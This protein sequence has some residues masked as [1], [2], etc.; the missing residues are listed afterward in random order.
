MPGPLPTVTEDNHPFVISSALDVS[1]GYAPEFITGKITWDLH[2]TSGGGRHPPDVTLSKMKELGAMTRDGAPLADRQEVLSSCWHQHYDATRIEFIS[3]FLIGDE[4][5]GS[6]KLNKTEAIKRLVEHNAPF[7]P[8]SILNAHLR[9]GLTKFKGKST[10]PTVTWEESYSKFCEEVPFGANVSTHNRNQQKLALAIDFWKEAMVSHNAD[11]PADKILTLSDEEVAKLSGSQF[12]L[13]VGGTPV[14]KKPA[15]PT[16]A[17]LR[18]K[19]LL[20]TT[21]V[22]DKKETIRQAEDLERKAAELRDSVSVSSHGSPS[23]RK[24]KPDA[25][26]ADLDN[27]G[28][29]ALLLFLSATKRKVELGDYID[30]ASMSAS[31]MKEIK[32]LNCAS[33]KSSRLSAGLVLRHSLSEADVTILTDDFSQISDGFLYHYLKVVSESNLDNPLATVI[34]R[35]SWWQW[36]GR[37][38]GKNFAAQV[39]FIKNFLLEHHSEPFWTPLVKLE[40]NLV[41]LCKEQAPLPG[42]TNAAKKDSSSKPAGKGKGKGGKGNNQSRVVVSAAQQKKIDSWKV[43]FPRT[44]VSRMV[45]GRECGREKSG[46]VCA[47]THNCAWCGSASCKADCS[48]AELL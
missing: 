5:R 14:F 3:Q 43:R 20:M 31:R 12:S 41:I 8:F 6:M 29:H 34:D 9:H 21:V 35:L 15:T 13:S 47:F 36:M 7:I 16:E 11:A 46:G 1:F 45:R 37:V 26:D 18:A 38:F 22:K 40:T 39:K 19:L 30:F 24:H 23:K 33:S 44:C 42:P 27:Q 4:I 32:M 28:T 10:F 2:A 25:D 48:Q 17:E